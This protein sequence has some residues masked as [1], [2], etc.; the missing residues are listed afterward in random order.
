MV[1]GGVCLLCVTFVTLASGQDCRYSVHMVAEIGKKIEQARG[2]LSREKLAREL[3]VSERTVYRWEKG[4]NVPPSD[5]L[6][7]IAEITARPVEWFFSEDGAA[8]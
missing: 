8:A 6:A 7:R 3:D 2:E 4:A 5:M 1:T